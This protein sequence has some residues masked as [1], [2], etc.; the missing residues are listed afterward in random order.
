M[1]H[2]ER[3]Y[4]VGKIKKGER[5]KSK[6]MEDKDEVNTKEMEEDNNV[7]LQRALNET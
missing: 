7:H 6:R 4:F 1:E 5:R 3:L 2:Q